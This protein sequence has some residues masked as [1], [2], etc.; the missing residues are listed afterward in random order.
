MRI[1]YELTTCLSRNIRTTQLG[2]DTPRRPEIIDNFKTFKTIVVD[3][4]GKLANEGPDRHA[5]A[6][7]P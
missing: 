6:F 4:I 3:K 7:T 1:N 5:T 2:H